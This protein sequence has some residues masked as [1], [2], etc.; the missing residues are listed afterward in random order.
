[1]ST[2]ETP[3]PNRRRL[4]NSIRSGRVFQVAAVGL[5]ALVALVIIALLYGEL[6]EFFHVGG[7]QLRDFMRQ[8]AYLPGFALLYVEESGVPLPAPGDV[9]VMYV[10]THVPHVLW[11]WI[12]AW[13][14][15]IVAVVLGATNLFLISRR[16]GRRLVGSSLAEYVHLTP[17]RVAKAELWVK[18]YRGLAVIFGRHIPGFRIPITV[19]SG[20]F[21]VRYPMFAAS[22]AVST[23]IWA[24]VVLIIGINYG[25]HLADL[26]RAHSF[27]YFVWGA[28]VLTLVGS[29]FIR[30]QLRRRRAG[31]SVGKP[32]RPV[33]SPSS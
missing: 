2:A 28:L 15:L 3:V 8:N 19:A 9:F 24:G 25:P 23:A 21:E 5:V 29:I 31:R 10:A 14:G 4:L 33:E 27:L 1:M 7:Q 26:L 12:A 18:R 32:D 17:E 20:I 30:Q 6:P 11:A 16:F 22:V 13:L